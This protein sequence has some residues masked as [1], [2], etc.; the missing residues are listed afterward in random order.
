MSILIYSKY[1]NN[2]YCKHDIL[3]GILFVICRHLHLTHRVTAI[4][5]PS[6]WGVTLTSMLYLLSCPM[7]LWWEAVMLNRRIFIACFFNCPLSR[8][9]QPIMI[10]GHGIY[11]FLTEFRWTIKSLRWMIR[12]WSAWRKRTRLPSYATRKAP[13]SKC[14]CILIRS[15]KTG[16]LIYV[17]SCWP[18][19]Y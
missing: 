6:P 15:A 7:V 5:P 19:T 16:I 18:T 9:V 13:W 12:V 10:N 8:S 4:Y 17:C 3:L 11:L 14:A 1:Q 2:V